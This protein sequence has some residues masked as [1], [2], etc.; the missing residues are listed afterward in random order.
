MVKA[1][2]LEDEDMMALALT[3]AFLDHAE[4]GGLIPELELEAL[5]QDR[6]RLG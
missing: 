2:L 4:V 1:G 6:R 3:Q 5:R